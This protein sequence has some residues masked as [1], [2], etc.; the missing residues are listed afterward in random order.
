M[1]LLELSSFMTRVFVRYILL[2]IYK[3]IGFLSSVV[4]SCAV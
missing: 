2:V 3:F 4:I 1:S